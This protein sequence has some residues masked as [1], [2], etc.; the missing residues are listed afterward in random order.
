M[1]FFTIQFSKIRKKSSR[2]HSS[3]TFKYKSINENVNPFQ[4][5][6]QNISSINNANLWLPDDRDFVMELEL[7]KP[8][9]ILAQALF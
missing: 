2:N 5:N 3:C 7:Y 6:Q 8:W 1:Y 4:E 9:T